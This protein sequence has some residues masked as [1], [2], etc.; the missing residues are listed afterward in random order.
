VAAAA[1]AGVL[2]LGGVALAAEWPP[3]L[4]GRDDYPPAV[5]RAI[6]R[7]W[8]DPT[9]VREIHAAP[10]PVPTDLYLAFVDTPDVTAAAARHLGRA[11]YDVR[12]VADDLYEANDHAG[13][14][15]HYRVL[16]RE[17]TRRVLLSWGSHAGSLL[18]TIE[19]SALTVLDFRAGNGR[20]EPRL[21]AYVH[22]DNR[23]AARLARVLITIFGQVAD[24]KLTRG[25]AVTAAVAE[26]AATHPEAFCAW[27]EAEA[28]PARH[29]APFRALLR[30][31]HRPAHADG[32]AGR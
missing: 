4:P 6:E 13:A 31:C 25:F 14:R 27:L 11:R 3:F 2:A 24:R 26:W 29:K 18:G 9:L 1:V 5:V 8:I 10:A 23:L 30:P 19:G 15:G 20:V 7:V 28:L 21:A 16:L 32:S 12:L 22:I 17:P